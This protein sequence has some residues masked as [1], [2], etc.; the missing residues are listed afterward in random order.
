VYHQNHLL[1]QGA[2]N[3][4]YLVG[5][6]EESQS[7]DDTRSAHPE[8]ISPLRTAPIE[9]DHYETPNEYDISVYYRP[10]GA[11]YDRLIGVATVYSSY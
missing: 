7:E 10:V 1:K 9:G 5:T 11:R 4:L 8:E 2:Y 3:Y 6:A